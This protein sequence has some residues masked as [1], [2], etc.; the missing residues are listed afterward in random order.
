M[1]DP[2]STMSTASL[3]PAMVATQA[4]CG[5]ATRLRLN[6]E[7]ARA[8]C[9]QAQPEG[10]RSFVVCVEYNGVEVRIVQIG[11]HIDMVRGVDKVVELDDCGDIVRDPYRYINALRLVTVVVLED[12][13]LVAEWFSISIR[14]PSFTSI[15][16]RLSRLAVGQTVKVFA[17]ARVSN[18]PR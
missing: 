13:R 8:R 6:S 12:N 11:R 2:R 5:R 10:P 9:V 14:A 7:A 1:D 16:A 15:L 17:G 4:P 3:V 18:D